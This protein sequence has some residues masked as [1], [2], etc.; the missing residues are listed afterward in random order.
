M[1]AM[2]II[3]VVGARPN[4]MKVAPIWNELKKRPDEFEPILVHTGQH[5]DAKMSDVFMQ[6]LNLPDPDYHLEVGSGSH[7]VQTAKV[8]MAFEPILQDEKPDLVVVV[9]DVNSTLACALD[10]AKLN[11][12]VAHVEA[13]LRSGDRS[14]PEEINRILTDAVSE[15]LL[16]PAE[17]AEENLL[18]EGI[19]KEK[20]HFVGNVMIDSLRHLEQR[21][22]ESQILNQL[23]ISTGEYVFLTLH[24]PSNVDDRP[25]LEGILKAMD[26][27]HSRVP[28]VFA[29]HPR[30]EKMIDEFDLRSMMNGIRLIEP[31]GYLDSLKLQKNS[32]FVLTDSGG[33]QEETTAFGI[34][35]LTIRENTERPVTVTAGTN[36]LVGVDPERI[37]GEAESIVDGRY[38][39][40]GLPDKWDGRTSERI[41]SAFQSLRGAA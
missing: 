7:A 33:L 35:C 16:T 26:H 40:G 6:E 13:G 32:M 18:R 1:V 23:C 5:Y 30:T 12:P 29:I 25:T 36:T 38:K 20:I 39:S 19:A 28:I 4:F 2:K 27:I 31:V 8:L 10:A 15:L 11:I 37:A 41:A 34:P 14:M 22:D 24:R 17:D 9:G 21:A 3:L